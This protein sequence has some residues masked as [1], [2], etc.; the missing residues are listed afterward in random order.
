MRLISAAES[1]R[2]SRLLEALSAGGSQPLSAEL[3]AGLK[4]PSSSAACL[5]AILQINSVP[6]PTPPAARRVL[7]SDAMPRR[8]AARQPHLSRLPPT[9]LVHAAHLAPGAKLGPPLSHR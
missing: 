2:L 8:A 5:A 6:E 1:M 4:T 3:L 7:I 9:A